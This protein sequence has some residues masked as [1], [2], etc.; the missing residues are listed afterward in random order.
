MKT[1]GRVKGCRGYPFF[2]TKQVQPGLFAGL[3]LGCYLKQADILG[4]IKRFC[5]ESVRVTIYR[6]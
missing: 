4:G 2:S 5:L 6:L 3:I 1:D